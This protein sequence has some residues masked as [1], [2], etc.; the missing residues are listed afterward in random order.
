[1][2]FE[3][4]RS[5]LKIDQTSNDMARPVYILDEG[6]NSGAL[7]GTPLTLCC[8]FT[9]VDIFL[10]ESRVDTCVVVRSKLAGDIRI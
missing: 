10:N 1:M 2:C 7:G 8:P 4:T 3:A 5:H 6:V 9:S